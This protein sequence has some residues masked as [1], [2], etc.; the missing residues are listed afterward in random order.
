MDIPNSLSDVLLLPAILVIFAI[1]TYGLATVA[2]VQEDKAPKYR[3]LAYV[4]LAVAMYVGAQHLYAAYNPDTGMFYRAGLFS[5]KMLFAHY[6]SFFAPLIF[7]IGAIFY[8]RWYRKYSRLN[9]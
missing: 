8:E 6:V 4:F 2:K 9:Y 7:L 1:L 3:Y 5:K